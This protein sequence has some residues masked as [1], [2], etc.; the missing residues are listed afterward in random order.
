MTNRSYIDQGGKMVRRVHWFLV[1]IFST[2]FVITQF[3]MIVNQ[4]CI[5]V[6]LER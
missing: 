1:A 2:L 5:D 4:H 6:H 3:E